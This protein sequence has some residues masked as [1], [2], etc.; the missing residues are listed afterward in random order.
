MLYYKPSGERLFVKRIKKI[1]F[2]YMVYDKQI[3]YYKN[4]GIRF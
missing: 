1:R 4:I 2:T 3:L